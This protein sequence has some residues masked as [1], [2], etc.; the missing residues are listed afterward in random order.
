MLATEVLKIIELPNESTAIK[1]WAAA[2]SLQNQ[3]KQQKQQTEIGEDAEWAKPS[4]M[5]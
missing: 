2:D 5:M 3:Q 1:H 4:S